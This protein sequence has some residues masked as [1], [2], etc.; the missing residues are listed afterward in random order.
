MRRN[1]DF[2]EGDPLRGVLDEHLADQV[3]QLGRDDGRL[4]WWNQ[5]VM[6]KI[7]TI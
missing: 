1:L 6:Y 4:E 7:S 3:L 2:R 5:V